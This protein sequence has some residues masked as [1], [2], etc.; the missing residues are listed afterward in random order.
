MYRR[1]FGGGGGRLCVYIVLLDGEPGNEIVFYQ[2]EVREERHY[3]NGNTRAIGVI[4]RPC[5]SCFQ[6]GGENL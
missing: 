4:L 3:V 5:Y 1:L 2:A 6:I